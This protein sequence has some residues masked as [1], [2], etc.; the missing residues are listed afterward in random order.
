MTPLE[1]A[2]SLSGN[3]PAGV[4]R[5]LGTY[6][7]YDRGQLTETVNECIFQRTVAVVWYRLHVNLNETVR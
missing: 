5:D 4:F 7:G 1:D 3:Y 2:Y 6:S